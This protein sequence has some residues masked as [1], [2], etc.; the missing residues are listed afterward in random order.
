MV[1]RHLRKLWGLPG[2]Q[3]GVVAWP[4]VRRDKLFFSWNYWWQA[5]LID[6]AVDA[7]NRAPSPTRHRRLTRITRSH[8]IRNLTGWTNNFYDDM[9]W[10]GIALDR[11][12]RIALIDHRGAIADL[13]DQIYDSWAPKSG[14]GIPWCKG[15]EFYNTPANGP[16]G[17]LLAR[18]GKLA[19]ARQMAD[20]I[21]E[22]LHDPKSDLI[23]DG[24][25]FTGRD[26][27]PDRAI[28]SYCQG[29]VLGLETELAVRFGDPRH[30]KRV[31]RLVNAVDKRLT[32]GGVITG[33]GGGDGGLFNGILARY[34]ALV[35][36][37]LPGES[38][39]DRRTR[40]I[41]ADIVM[42]SA[43]AAWSHSARVAE[44]PLFGS[45]WTRPAV[46]PGA[47]SPIARFDG[48]TV[49]SSGVPERDLSV[50]LS[51]WMLMEAA[52]L[53]SAAGF[54]EQLRPYR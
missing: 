5:H 33:G 39:S 50:Q 44:Q 27:G 41:A 36:V 6:C 22:N 48:G 34:L 25:R 52:Y 26:A 46:V 40:A 54:S 2:T 12:Q 38:A 11:A 35:A 4:A 49:R 21:D 42:A 10:L 53:V 47:D 20:W 43:E 15:S 9:A 23:I 3:L 28:F 29:V 30:A 8:R 31:H 1:T 37:M 45:D 16:G 24:I 7:A 32:A 51:G 19:R 17:I 18:T 13:E 14:G